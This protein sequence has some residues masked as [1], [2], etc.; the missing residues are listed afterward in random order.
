MPAMPAIPNRIA[1]V[2]DAD[3]VTAVL[4][5]RLARVAAVETRAELPAGLAFDV[6][7]Y[8]PR[9]DPQ[10]GPDLVRAGDFF[11]AAPATGARRLVLLSSAEV[12]EPSHEH[13]GLTSEPRALSLHRLGPLARS[14]A[15][16]E[17]QAAA[18]GLE[19]LILRPTAVVAPDSPDFLSRLLK[20]RLAFSLPGL[21]PSI[22][23]LDPADLAEAVALAVEKGLP[24]VYQVTPAGTVPLR[25]AIRLAGA[26]RLPLPGF[27]Q[28]LSASPDEIA[29]LRYPATVSGA[30]AERELGFVPRRTSA[31]AIAAAFGGD[32]GATP[33]V[34]DYGMSV[35]YIQ[36]Y[37]RTLFRFLHDVYWRIEWQGLEN[38]P[39]QGRAVL[40]GVHRGFMPW[41]GV[42]AVH[43]LGRELGRYPRFLIHPCLVKFPFLANY[44]TKL[45][46]IL[47]CQENADWVLARDEMVGMFPEG[48]QG[49]FTMYRNAYKLGK[50]GRDEYVK[51]ALRNRA[52]IV[53]FVTVG[54]AEIY[55]ILGRINSRFV[56]QV[57][58]WPF[59]PLAPNFPLP[60]LPLPSKWHTRFLEP[61]PV[62]EK[63]GPEA[64]DD[65]RVVREI[66]REVRERMEAAIAGML[67]RRKSI[68]RGSVFD[69]GEK[70]NDAVS[71]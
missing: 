57:I 51:M 49:A 30:R 65:P 68:F 56:R 52:P 70:R 1:L 39:R 53:P 36:A 7:V 17:E 66:S 35:P 12:Y 28:R 54:S 43:L 46:G 32:P 67:A 16:L 41:D 69:A 10:G 5:A 55:P 47:A 24:G 40:T 8:R 13:P 42:M 59:L 18:V 48:I 20:R 71:S 23:L 64:A 4:A 62:Q 37:G 21:D 26:R 22:Q 2:A 27:L 58:E 50:F 61:L 19:L 63:Y 33:E 38:V 44:M 31:Q 3:G 29:F 15:E 11:A 9:R 45:G 34:D 60:G 25:A 6:L 14:W